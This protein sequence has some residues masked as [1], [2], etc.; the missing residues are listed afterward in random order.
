MANKTQNRKQEHLK[1]CATEDVSFKKKTT[2]FEEI[3]LPHAAISDISFTSICTKTTFVKKELSAPLMIGAMSGGTGDNSSFNRDLAIC[4]DELGIALSLGSIRPW[5]ENPSLK[6]EY[7]VKNEAMPPLLFANIGA[8][9]LSEYEPEKIFDF[10]KTM[11]ADAILVHINPAMEIIQPEGDTD[12]SNVSD[13]I[14]ALAEVFKNIPV[15]PKGTGMGLSFADGRILKEAG[16]KQVEVAGA[17][18]TSWIGV[19]ALRAEGIKKD[20]GHLLWDFGIPTAVSTAWMV[21]IGFEVIASGGIYSGL[22]MARALTLGAKLCAVA[23]P[24]AKAWYQNGVKGVKSELEKMI[25]GLKYTMICVG[26]STPS[27]FENIPRVMGS[28]L[29]K[30]IETGWTSR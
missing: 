12:F 15:I 2:L 8:A 17:G 25:E 18:G 4:A 26:I 7:T 29:Q 30:Y 5:L 28:K 14:A 23:R 10:V 21:D 24:V 6:N 9:Q 11:K 19:E 1:I 27:E 16:I 22:D 3:E 20:M 13:N